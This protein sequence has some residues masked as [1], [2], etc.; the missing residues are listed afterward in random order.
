MLALADDPAPP[1]EARAEPRA[2]SVV[3]YLIDTCRADRMSL[4]GN[5]RETTP[6]LDSLAGRSIVFE[7]CYS[8]A[9][10]TKPSMASILTSRYPSETGIQRIFSASPTHS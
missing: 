4:Y 6:F 3:F 7:R 5:E 2:P 9:P 8:Q 1:A 10:W